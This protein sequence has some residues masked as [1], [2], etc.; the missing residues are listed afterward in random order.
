MWAGVGEHFET[1]TVQLLAD[2]PPFLLFMNRFLRIA[3]SVSTA[4]AFF[5]FYRDFR[6]L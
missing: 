4:E 3:A 6:F 1:N 2:S 5:R